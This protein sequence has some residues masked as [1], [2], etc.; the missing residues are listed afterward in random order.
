MK[1]LSI[2]DPGKESR[3]FSEER[4]AL[5]PGPET[6]L[7]TVEAFG[8]NRADLLQRAGRYPAPADVV[9]D[10]PGLEYAGSIAELGEHS[11]K[12]RVGDRVMGIVSGGAYADHLLAHVHH[13]I[14][15]P[16][17][18]APHEAASVPEAYVTAWDALSLQGEMKEGDKVLI[19][20]VG[21][22]VGRAAVELCL[23]KGA[24]PVGTSRTPWK[25]EKIQKQYGIETVLRAGEWWKDSG[26]AQSGEFD[27]ILDLVGGPEVNHSLGLLVS[28]GALIVVGLTAGIRAEL[29]LDILLG[30]RARL[31]GTVLRSRS[32]H[33]KAALMSRFGREVLPLFERGE[34]HSLCEERYSVDQ[35]EQA[36]QRMGQNETFGKLVVEW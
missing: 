9:Q 8:I 27:L 23:A 30:K 33:E 19:H 7:I 36:H 4:P 14:P 1:V 35:I 29:R 31:M 34:L 2:V 28:R 6:A 20:A 22:G 17:G 24:I 26:W 3:M 5:Q 18:F 15:I 21:S 16:E 10:V 13:L 25:L 12:W 32:I 11:S